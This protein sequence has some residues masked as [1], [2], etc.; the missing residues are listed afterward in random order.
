MYHHYSLEQ[1]FHP[2]SVFARIIPDVNW[3]FEC[4]SSILMF[5]ERLKETGLLAV[6]EVYQQTCIMSVQKYWKKKSKL[7]INSYLLQIGFYLFTSVKQ[8]CDY[9]LGGYFLCQFF[10]L[11]YFL[12]Q[13]VS[14]L[15]SMSDMKSRSQS[16]GASLTQSFLWFTFQALFSDKKLLESCH[17]PSHD[18]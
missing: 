16:A 8:F 10:I 4:Q 3:S 2:P 9:F 18:K 11:F 13:L 5:D 15:K 12:L 6:Q 1:L 17:K 14:C 7:F